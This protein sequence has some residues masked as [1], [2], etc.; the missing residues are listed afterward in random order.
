MA[1]MALALTY[2]LLFLLPLL[3]V[4]RTLA[5][6]NRK[7][8]KISHECER[9]LV[10]GGTS[11]IGREIARRYVSRGA[12]VCIVGRGEDKLKETIEECR[13]LNSEASV[14]GYTADLAGVEDM[15]RLRRHLEQDFQGLDT[16]IVAAGVS[17]V[18]P[19]LDIAGVQS[20]RDAC[21]EGIERAVTVANAAL[22]SNFTGPLVAAVTLIPLLKRTSPSPSIL[23][24][25]SLGAVIPA[26]TRTIYGSTKGASLILYQALAIEHPSIRFSSVLP[27]T[28][29]GDFRASAVDIDDRDSKPSSWNP[30]GLK[31]RDVAQRCIIAVDRREKLVFF[32]AT[33]RLGHFLYWIWPSFIER[34]AKKKYGFTAAS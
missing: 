4:A 21:S 31:I 29:E 10:L 18:R 17:A 25:S 11:G 3:L 28:V 23:L 30:E 7:V 13:T 5:S 27:S 19:L 2:W 12:K 22:K 20:S 6:S 24:I 16:M 14:F 34:K 32:P 1:H 33:M 8:R 15:T 9:V 26:P